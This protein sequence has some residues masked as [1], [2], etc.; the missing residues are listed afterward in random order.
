MTAGR[1]VLIVGRRVL[2][3]AAAGRLEN[4]PVVVAIAARVEVAGTH[5]AH[6]SAAVKG[7]PGYIVFLQVGQGS[8]ALSSRDNRTHGVAVQVEFESKF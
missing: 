2:I 5:T 8:S 4:S 1:R 7:A 3:V 6:G